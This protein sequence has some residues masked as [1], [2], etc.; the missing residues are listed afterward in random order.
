MRCFFIVC[1][2]FGIHL[3]DQRPC[4]DL[5]QPD[6]CAYYGF[7]ELDAETQAETPE[8]DRKVS[9]LAT[10]TEANH[11]LPAGIYQA[12]AETR[13]TSLSST[14][15]SSLVES[16]L[17]AAS[18]DGDR[19]TAL[20]MWPMQKNMQAISS[21]VP[22]VRNRMDMARQE[23]S[24]RMATDRVDCMGLAVILV[25]LIGKA[26]IATKKK[27]T[28]TC[29]KSHSEPP[30]KRKRRERTTRWGWKV[31]I[32]SFL[33]YTYLVY[34]DGSTTGSLCWRQPQ[35]RN[36]PSGASTQRTAFGR[37]SATSQSPQSVEECGDRQRRC[38]QSCGASGSYSGQRGY[39]NIQA[40]GHKYGTGQEGSPGDRYCLEGISES[41][42]PL[43][44]GNAPTLGNT[45]TAVREW[46]TELCSSTQGSCAK[47]ARCEVALTGH[48]RESHSCRRP[49][50]TR[51]RRRRRE[52]ECAGHLRNYHAI[53]ETSRC[54]VGSSDYDERIY[55]GCTVPQ[56]EN[57]QRTRQGDQGSAQG[58]RDSPSLGRTAR[59]PSDLQDRPPCK[60]SRVSW[61]N[62]V[63]WKDVECFHTSET[64][65]TVDIHQPHLCWSHSIVLEPDF[66]SPQE[67]RR[68]AFMLETEPENIEFD[69]HLQRFVQIDWLN[70]T[71]L[72]TDIAMIIM[73]LEDDYF[74]EHPSDATEPLH[75]EVLLH[76]RTQTGIT[77]TII[78][79][80]SMEAL[81]DFD[82]LKNVI[83]QTFP[84]FIHEH[85]RV[86]HH[87][88]RCPTL[89]ND[90]VLHIL[91]DE[92]TI[93]SPVLLL[94]TN[95]VGEMHY[96]VNIVTEDITIKELAAFWPI[97]WESTQSF[98]AGKIHPMDSPLTYFCGQTVEIDSF[99]YGPNARM[100]PIHHRVPD[101]DLRDP[102]ELD[103]A[104]DV[105]MQQLP[106]EDEEDEDPIVITQD[107]ER[108]LLQTAAQFDEN[109]P[110]QI[111]M[112]GVTLTHQERR[113]AESR[114][115]DHDSIMRTIAHTWEDYRAHLL[116]PKLV[117]QQPAEL[118]QDGIVFIVILQHIMTE[119]P[120]VPNGQIPGLATI[121]MAPP[122]MPPM[123]HRVFIADEMIT[124]PEI[125]RALDMREVCT[126]LGNREC[127]VRVGGAGTTLEDLTYEAAE[128][129]WVEVHIG[130]LAQMPTL[131]Q[132]LPQH[133]DFQTELRGFWSNFPSHRILCHTYG[134]R[135]RF[136]GS[137]H[138]AI[139]PTDADEPDVY[140]H[141]MLRGWM[142]HPLQRARAYRVRALDYYNPHEQEAHVHFIIAFD[143]RPGHSICA[144]ADTM[145]TNDVSVIA[146][147]EL[148]PP[149]AWYANELWEDQGHPLRPDAY[150]VV[151][152][153]ARSDAPQ[154]QPGDFLLYQ[155]LQVPDE[156][157]SSLLQSASKKVTQPRAPLRDCT[158][159]PNDAEDEQPGLHYRP[160]SPC[161]EP[162]HEVREHE[163][164]DGKPQKSSGRPLKLFPLLFE[165]DLAVPLPCT[166]EQ[167]DL[168]LQACGEFRL[169]TDIPAELLDL[170]PSVTRAY[171][172]TCTS[173][174][175]TPDEYHIYT[176]GSAKNIER[177]G[178]DTRD[179]T[180]ALVVF[181]VKD[182][183]R[184][185][186]GWT[187]G[188]VRI[189]PDSS[190]W[191][192]AEK[193]QAMDAERTA[194]FWATAWTLGLRP[195]QQLCF[196]VGNM[197]AGL[198]A[199]GD[200]AINTSQVLAY[201]LRQMHLL[202]QQRHTTSMTHVKAH[203]LSPQNE[204]V[205]QMANFLYDNSPN[206]GNP[207]EVLDRIASFTEFD[208]LWHHLRAGQGLPLIWENHLQLPPPT[209][210]NEHVEITLQRP[211]EKIWRAG[212]KS[213]KC[214]IDLFVVT[215]NV[216]TLGRN[217]DKK[218]L[219][220]DSIF[221]GKTK[222][223]SEQIVQQN[224][225][226][227]ALQE[228]RCNVSGIFQSSEILR[229]TSAGTPEGTHGVELWFNRKRPLAVYDNT[230]IFP[231]KENMVV[232]HADPRRLLVRIKLPD[233]S[234][235]CTSMH[236][237]QSGAEDTER[238][239][240]WS[241]T[242]ELLRPFRHRDLMILAADYNARLPHSKPP[243][244]GNLVCEKGNKNTEYFYNFIEELNLMAPS[245]HEE[246]HEGTTTTWRHA[247][248][249][250]A[251][252]DYVLTPKEQWQ[253]IRSTSW[254][255]LDVGN[256]IPDHFPTG[257]KIQFYGTTSCY[258]KTPKK[259]DWDSLC[260]PENTQKL[261]SAV[262]QIPVA[263]WTTTATEQV[264]HLNNALHDKLCETFPKK[265]TS[266]RRPYIS[267]ATWALRQRRQRLLTALRTMHL[268]EKD[269]GLRYV[270]ARWSGQKRLAPLL[271]FGVDMQVT[272]LLLGEVR[273]TAKQ[274]R[275]LLKEDKVNYIQNVA[276]K[277]NHTSPAAIYKELACFR[278]G[279]KF[280]KRSIEPLPVFH[281][282]DGS[283]ATDPQE[284]AEIWRLRCE[285]LESGCMT[286]AHQLWQ[287]A[288]AKA[289]QRRE[290]IPT[291][292]F[293]DIPSIVT[294]EAKLRKIKKGKAAGNDGFKSDLYALAAPEFAVHLH[295][296][297]AKFVCN[298]DEAIH[299]KGGTLIAAYKQPVPTQIHAVIG[300][301]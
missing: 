35:W 276:Q 226:I 105:Q 284:R 117:L 85:C 41:V 207:G 60:P 285:E 289:K 265:G 185:L 54:D 155:Q 272:R 38:E 279:A 256:A 243:W 90:T 224:I 248:G 116:K 235:I 107:D 290:L 39:S 83:M 288:H 102:P 220:I 96:S 291:P 211:G 13:L 47:V 202:V 129:I 69:D 137:S 19:P 36:L 298:L 124:Q 212:T 259:I 283:A 125:L 23:L 160:R 190:R 43:L 110:V 132:I 252:L 201:R 135:Y 154:I 205:D 198:G 57:V 66:K 206:L 264:E 162:A 84:D 8:S 194:L 213:K 295:S 152:Y 98:V 7:S 189:E 182:S 5:D 280:R 227:A 130:R 253:S 51:S 299:H 221:L 281:H 247:T 214:L 215:Y 246:L 261:R 297:A 73:N 111:I 91:I 163:P 233:R 199:S 169:R 271:C 17:P 164:D 197:A 144:I 266:L 274:L 24:A 242:M 230:K 180:W 76:V 145:N 258:K 25:V 95:M 171:L 49:S 301:S 108:A 231:T 183:R 151:P 37:A 4:A 11:P 99:S 170:C 63:I 22:W 68:Q 119:R 97:P 228:C 237:P 53:Q 167:C 181:A 161:S 65:N 139:E 89:F 294:L 186:L 138:I 222:Y 149:H 33:A 210:P 27:P 200:W 216:L 100:K 34:S 74:M 32:E 123:K 58:T 118:R 109:E 188:G 103:R 9:S 293:E 203:T 52:H 78:D 75:V 174:D 29:T 172:E 238:Q 245:T 80:I 223:L 208:A 255:W 193:L 12:S 93:G 251:R 126:P 44:R 225:N 282:P 50:A 173:F 67:A 88:Q 104:I 184:M 106:E 177:I 292:V 300:A 254:S 10:Q 70:K 239:T 165:N 286:T 262:R 143:L 219:D 176:D 21:M 128:G 61:D 195:G 134:Y 209:A 79:V 6:R 153:D 287:Q 175:E 45:C 3:C 249:R 148:M 270:W 179:A 62:T 136:L 18:R 229:V 277:V 147:P 267:E 48:S 113:D 192:G 122:Y 131:R 244:I 146:G 86:H 236:A 77:H 121:T 112:F 71:N 26:T 55:R 28:G 81:Q 16:T 1:Y 260:D 241:S 120:V 232:L 56:K 273:A 72:D 157:G 101:E 196:F 133:E 257:L 30:P 168:F 14:I 156:D 87:V 40:I 115:H 142:R 127:N 94:W 278:A 64:H 150:Q 159:L 20:E 2:L 141:A 268:H 234:L 92:N 263:S 140:A 296:L 15:S 191:I 204:L 114:G 158:N 240:W 31:I 187:G 275:K 42:A 166:T 46:G 59:V 269:T 217:S 250:E 82:Q 178:L 218:D